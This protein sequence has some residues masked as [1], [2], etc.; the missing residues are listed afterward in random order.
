MSANRETDDS[1]THHDIAF[2]L[3]DAADEV[4]IGI[5]PTQ[6]LIRG[7]RRRKA[8]RWAV[9]A[10]TVVVV[11]GSTGALA[12]AGLPGGGER[13]APPA[14]RLTPSTTPDVFAP[15]RTTLATGT[16]QGKEWRVYID[17]WTAPTDE[18][19]AAAELQSM[20]EY[21]ERPADVDEPAGLVGKTSF[22]VHRGFGTTAASDPVTLNTF[23][24]DEKMAGRDLESAALPLV[25]G[26]DGPSRLVIGHVAKTAQEVTCTWKDGT[27]SV[28]RKA[29][30]NSEVATDELVIRTVEGSTSN[31]FVCLAPAGKDF[32]SVEVTG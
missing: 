11:A 23:P 8:R 7:G 29:P 4:E 21:G 5:A 22:F 28:V 18:V 2:L 31:W 3:A 13:G 1:M 6:S 27:T 19:E 16:E 15:H 12:V 14:T 26:T 25:P 20:G 10:A 32:K 24:K 30:S 17:V 9:A